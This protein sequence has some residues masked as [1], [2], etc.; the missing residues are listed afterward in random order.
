MYNDPRTLAVLKGGLRAPFF[1]FGAHSVVVAHASLH[2]ARHRVSRVAFLDGR[3]CDST[4]QSGVVQDS[5]FAMR[6]PHH[7]QYCSRWSMM[8][9]NSHAMHDI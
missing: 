9:A 1:L 5:I 3:Q 6:L 4:S 2:L 7:H 8:R